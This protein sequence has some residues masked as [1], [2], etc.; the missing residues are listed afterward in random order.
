MTN[1][2]RIRRMDDKELAETIHTLQGNAVACPDC[3]RRKGFQMLQI[4][5]EL[6]DGR[7]E[8]EREDL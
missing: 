7:K 3:F 8:D 4:W 2:E 1:A 6:D 5:L